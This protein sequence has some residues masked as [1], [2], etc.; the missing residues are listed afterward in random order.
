MA[1]NNGLGGGGGGGIVSNQDL[2][3]I[4]T[5]NVVSKSLMFFHLVYNIEHNIKQNIYTEMALIYLIPP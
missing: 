4:V 1:A 2:F 3:C 5:T